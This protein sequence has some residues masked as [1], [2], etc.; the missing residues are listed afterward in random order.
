MAEMFNVL[1]HIFLKAHRENI[2]DNSEET[3]KT[4]MP[5]ILV[6]ACPDLYLSDQPFSLIFHW[7]A[8]K[9]LK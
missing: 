9:V 7:I 2:N 6:P 5:H 8:Q 1:Q 3:S 4:M